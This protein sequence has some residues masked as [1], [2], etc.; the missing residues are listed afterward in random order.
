MIMEQNHSAPALEL[1]QSSNTLKFVLGQVFLLSSFIASLSFAASVLVPSVSYANEPQII[2]QE[3]G[4]IAFPKQKDPEKGCVMGRHIKNNV[5]AIIY[6]NNNE[7][8]QIGLTSA[9]WRLEQGTEWKGAIAFDSDRSIATT[10]RASSQNTVVVPS[11]AGEDSLESR[12]RAA[13]KVRITFNNE[14]FSISLKG[15]SNALDMLWSCAEGRMGASS[16]SL[17]IQ[18]GFYAIADGNCSDGLGPNV[19]YTDSKSL[20][21]PSSACRF[22]NV[23][24]I[25]QSQYSVKQTCGRNLDDVETTEDIYTIQSATRFSF[26]YGDQLTALNRC[27]PKTLPQAAGVTSP[28]YALPTTEE[29]AEYAR[30]KIEADDENG[31]HSTETA[32][33]TPNLSAI[34]CLIAVGGE[35]YADGACQWRADK[36]G[37]F[38]VYSGKYSAAVNVDHVSTVHSG[39]WNAGKGSYSQPDIAIGYMQQDGACWKSTTATICAWK[40]G[41]RQRGGDQQF[42]GESVVQKSMTGRIVVGSTDSAFEITGS[43]G[44]NSYGFLTQSNVGQEIFKICQMDNECRIEGNFNEERKWIEAVSHVE[45]MPSAPGSVQSEQTLLAKHRPGCIYCQFSY[46]PIRPR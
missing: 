42:P 8:F 20:N 24:K 28:F 14:T 36:S 18:S 45:K 19:I 12:I 44:G 22:E 26:K 15:S 16:F 34:D 29:I 17:P 11:G 43:D 1:A 32:N 39:Y 10:V 37:S 35:T 23:E 21:W 40:I 27:N 30:S 9:D 46:R 2:F 13:A 31:P 3:N 41:E 6:V 25:S 38:S 5:H 4:W 7:T 33:S